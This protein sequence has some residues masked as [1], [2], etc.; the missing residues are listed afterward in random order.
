[1]ADVL[2]GYSVK[3]IIIVTQRSVCAVIVS[4]QYT[5]LADIVR[6]VIFYL[7]VVYRNGKF[8]NL[9][10]YFFKNNILTVDKDEYISCPK[11][12]CVGPSL[13][14]TIERVG[15][16]DGA[17]LLEPHH[18]AYAYLFVFHIVSS[19]FSTSTIDIDPKKI[20]HENINLKYKIKSS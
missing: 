17:T 7:E 14:G 13:D 8:K 16:N 1:V 19:Y 11:I 2:L 9:M 3:C 12:Y 15:R 10:L 18:F 20:F 6:V 5:T 4:L